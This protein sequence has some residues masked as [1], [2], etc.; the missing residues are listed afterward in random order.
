MSNIGSHNHAKIDLKLTNYKFYDFYLTNDGMGYTPNDDNPIVWFDFNNNSTFSGSSVNTIYSLSGW[1]GAINSGYTIDTFGLTGLD[2]GY[3]LYNK[4]SGD[5]KNTN[6]VNILTGSTLII[7][8]G[9][10]NLILNSVSGSTNQFIYPIDYYQDQLAGGSVRLCGGF[11]QG[12]YKLDGYDY[13]VLPNRYGDGFTLDVWL[14]KEA[15]CSGYTGTTLNDKYPNNKGFFFYLGTRAENKFWNIFEGNNTGCTIDC[16]SIS[17]CGDSVTTFCTD[18]KETEIVLVDDYGY[19]IYLNPPISD[20]RTIK[21]QFLIYGRARDSI[22][23]GCGEPVDSDQY[24][25]HTACCFTGDSITTRTFRKIKTDFRNP[26]LIYG[27]AKNRN[28]NN[29]D[30]FSGSTSGVTCGCNVCCKPKDDDN[31]GKET[32]CSYSGDSD[33]VLE[34]DK[35]VDLIDNAIGFRIK[36]DGSI[37]YRALRFTGVCVDDVYQTGITVEEQYSLSGMVL[38]NEWTRITVRYKPD[39]YVDEDKLKCYKKR[40]GSLMFYIDCNL[41][42]K[43]DSVD[44]IIPKRLDEYNDKQIG[45]PYN[46]SIGG[47]TQG[48]LESMTFD[49]QDFDDL[50]LNIEKNFAGSFIGSISQFKLFDRNLNFSDISKGCLDTYNKYWSGTTC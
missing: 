22:C 18:I 32:V 2:N 49:G 45:V 27:R 16:E 29:N 1:S 20:I 37:G 41:K 43:F 24:G 13:E 6:L 11:Y 33:Y 34:I 42:A 44:E 46:I 40:K 15:G 28:C 31:Y 48:L 38:D 17:G 5:T 39:E 19:D 7:N 9:D 26:F 25:R 35:D 14:K 47:G 50:N 23:G 4:Q 30:I 21:N 12:F 36:D 3:L 10:T 8:S